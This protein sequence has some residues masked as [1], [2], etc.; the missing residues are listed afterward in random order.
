MALSDVRLLRTGDEYFPSLREAI[1]SAREAIFFEVYIFESDQTGRSIGDEL[2]AA[3][4]RGVHVHLLLDGW[5]SKGIA[6][7]YVAQLRQ[8]GVEVAFFASPGKYFFKLKQRVLR[9]LHR[10]IVVIDGRVA[11]VGGINVS[12]E[13][14]TLGGVPAL[15][16]YAL[17]V[18]GP[19][20]T[21]VLESS[22][23]LWRVA[24]ESRGVFHRRRV[25]PVLVPADA[26]PRLRF[27]TRDNLGNR[28]AIEN[29]Y[30]EALEAAR[31]QVYIV[32]A[33]FFPSR[34][35]RLALLR[36]AGRGVLVRLVLQGKVDEPVIRYATRAL[37]RRLLRQGIE[38]YEHH[39]AVV[40]AK[41][42]VFDGHLLTVGSSNLDPISLGLSLE[43]NLFA[44]HPV[45][46]R[47]LTSQIE[48]ELNKGCVKVELADFDRLAWPSRLLSWICFGIIRFLWRFAAPGGPRGST[49]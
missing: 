7:D 28:T 9:R 17:R 32:N 43:A 13:Q 37:Y 44:E 8:A 19:V 48:A 27:V 20:V 24:A 47:V 4:R 14:A 35:F 49:I 26:D 30:L 1:A 10:K 23:E 42:A 3:A 16:D 45:L 22:R 36:A 6:D 25:R 11:F 34:R 40:H 29:H 31:R 21:Y 2:A 33:Y 38:I 18:E 15:Y 39:G 41:V 12:N 46:T 5:G